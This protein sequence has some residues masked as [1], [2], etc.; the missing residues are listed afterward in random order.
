MQSSAVQVISD[1][2]IPVLAPDLQHNFILLPGL[3][4][5]ETLT[6][7]ILTPQLCA[8]LAYGRKKGLG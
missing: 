3:Y 5:A 7:D 1:P 2:K 4:G 8:A 6:D